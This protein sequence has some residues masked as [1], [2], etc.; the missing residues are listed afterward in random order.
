MANKIFLITI[1]DL[2]NEWDWKKNNALNLNPNTLCTGSHKKAFW[3]C[4]KHNFEYEQTIRDKAQKGYLTCK[5]CY[6]EKWSPA[7]RERYAKGKKVLAETHPHLLNEWVKCEDDKITPYN[8]VAGANKKVLWKCSTCGGQFSAYISNRALKNSRCPYC[9]G[10][11]VLQGKTDL[12][13]QNP[14]LAKEWSH[15]NSLQPTE[16]AQFSKKKV[17]WICP[18]GHPDYL[19]TVQQRSNG[20]GCPICASQSQT[21][22]PE[23]A[24]YFYLKKIF[25]DAVNRFILDKK[26]E[27]DIFI[28]SKNIGIE[29][30]GY[31][32]HKDKQSKDATKKSYITNMGLDLIV[33]REFKYDNE[34]T[35]ADYYIHESAKPKD[36]N[37]LITTIL[38][39]IFGDFD[40][41]IDVSLDLIEIQEQYLIKKKERS[42]S[43][44]RPDLLLEWDYKKN[45]KITPELVTIGSKIKYYWIC[46][47]CKYSYSCS[48]YDKSKGISCPAHKNKIIITGKNDFASQYPEL[49][50]Y[51]DYENN[52][53]SPNKVYHNS[54]KKYNWICEQGHRYNSSIVDIV[55]SKRCPICSNARVLAGYN[56]LLSQNPELAKEWDYEL[57]S[58]HPSEIYY[59]SQMPPVHW[60]CSKC[61][62]KWASKVHQRTGCPNCKE[63]KTAIN[64]YR[65]SDKSYYG[66]FANARELC[67]HFGIDYNKKH[68]NISMICNRKQQSLLG[69]YILRH[70]CDDEF[71]QKN[72]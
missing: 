72:T 7:R 38:S 47:I 35:N 59:K 4:K 51:W 44:L 58:I 6:E 9:T 22:F 40:F 68:G 69:K 49:L 33:I 13:T 54:T 2:M 45:G 10:I 1:P 39:D 29:Y 27:I 25:P 57:N 18:F 36:L 52:K 3:I 41:N 42:I 34:K 30:N 16:V 21:S 19:M 32:S 53:I 67:T 20:S 8:C 63:Q 60:I 56:D 17:Y 64:V 31:F 43:N 12:L 70:P 14:K 26:Y 62:H 24:L 46:P 71:G 66:T 28:P 50:K 48:P 23:Q 61:G 5:L 15:K 11:K 37:Q 55:K 65:I